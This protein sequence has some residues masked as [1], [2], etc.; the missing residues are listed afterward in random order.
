M[1]PND[2]SLRGMDLGFYLKGLLCPAAICCLINEVPLLFSQN[3][4]WCRTLM[5]VPLSQISNQK[6]HSSNVNVLF[7]PI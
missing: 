3:K 6:S 5:N 2:C 7:K 1:H 4:M